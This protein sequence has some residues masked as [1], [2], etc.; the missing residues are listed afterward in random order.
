MLA[1][2]AIPW[3]GVL[4]AL[5]A[6]QVAGVRVQNVDYSGNDATAR[7]E[8]VFTAQSQV[9]DY[10]TELNAGLPTTGLA[11][12]WTVLRIEQN[13]GDANGRALVVGRWAER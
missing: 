11:W 3:P 4:T 9:L 5:E 10:V 12:R 1:Q 2:H 13:K 7:V 6:V 8:V